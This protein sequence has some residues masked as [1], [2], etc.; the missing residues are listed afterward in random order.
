MGQVGRRGFL[1]EVARNTRHVKSNSSTPAP[2]LNSAVKS[3]CK[4]SANNGAAALWRCAR[5]E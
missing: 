4:P 5:K 1:V 2:Q 3:S